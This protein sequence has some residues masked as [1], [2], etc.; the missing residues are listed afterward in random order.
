MET[1]M[2]KTNF[3]L[4]MT[5]M[6]EYTQTHNEKDKAQQK[7]VKLKQKCHFSLYKTGILNV[8]MNLAIIIIIYDLIVDDYYQ[9]HTY[10]GYA[11]QR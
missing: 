4:Q 1:E 8:K 3:F 11:G 10:I 2:I 6:T 7:K 9:T 5:C